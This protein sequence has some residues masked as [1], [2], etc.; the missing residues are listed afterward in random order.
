MQLIGSKLSDTYPIRASVCHVDVED[1]DTKT[2]VVF[3]EDSLKFC[4]QQLGALSEAKTSPGIERSSLKLD[5][6]IWGGWALLFVQ[7]SIVCWERVR[8]PCS[9][10]GAVEAKRISGIQWSVYGR[11][12]W[13]YSCSPVVTVDIDC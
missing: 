8:R 5:N 3:V 2:E 13:F 7:V 1:S 9:G 6:G 4:V 11:A 10:I 12:T